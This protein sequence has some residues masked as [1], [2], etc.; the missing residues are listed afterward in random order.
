MKQWSHL[1]LILAVILLQ[2]AFLPINVAEGKKSSQGCG[3]TS[4]CGNCDTRRIFDEQKCPKWKE[5]YSILKKKKNAP[6]LISCYRSN[7]CQRQL[8]NC[9]NECGASGTAAKPGTSKHELACAF[10]LRCNANTKIVDNALLEAKATA[11]NIRDHGAACNHYERE[12]ATKS[13]RPKKKSKRPDPEPEKKPKKK[14]PKEENIKDDVPG[15]DSVAGKSSNDE[16]KVPDAVPSPTGKDEV[17]AKTEE[18]KEEADDNKPDEEETKLAS[19]PIPDSEEEDEATQN[20]VYKRGKKANRY[21]QKRFQKYDS[22][23]MEDGS[24]R[25]IHDLWEESGKR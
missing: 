11:H 21:V 6:E 13:E 4:E 15:T 17:D 23:K 14:K 5:F 8:Y 16:V 22:E 10:D 19:R 9:F 1:F 24:P 2:T 20:K 18:T 25:W 7:H 3:C 12:V